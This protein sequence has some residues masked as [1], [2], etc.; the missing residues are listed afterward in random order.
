MAMTVAALRALG[1]R[2]VRLSTVYGSYDGRIAVDRLSDD[3]VVIL[4]ARE[5]DAGE[6]L[7]VPL[8]SIESIVER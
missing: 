4:F 5:G 8:E 3:A 7:V 6:P 2:R 1:N